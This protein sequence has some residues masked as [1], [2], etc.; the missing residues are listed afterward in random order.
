MKAAAVL[1]SEPV[2]HLKSSASERHSGSNAP[3]WPLLKLEMSTVRGL[4]PSSCR[5]TAEAVNQGDPTPKM[6]HVGAFCSL[7]EMIVRLELTERDH[8]RRLL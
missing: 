3:R 7:R 1:F 8:A 6:S 2:R 5:S 4:I